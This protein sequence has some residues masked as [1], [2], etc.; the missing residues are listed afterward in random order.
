MPTLL[1][2][3]R[4]L[5]AAA[6]LVGAA[7]EAG[8]SL[9]FL[10]EN[11]ACAPG[12]D[13]VYYGGSDVALAAARRFHLT[14]LEPPLDLVVRLPL[15]F[16]QRAVEYARFD[17]LHRLK[18]PTF[19][20]PA[21]PLNKAFDAGIYADVR[22]IRAPKGIAPATPVLVAEPVEWLAEYRCFVLDR[23]VAATTPYLSFGRPVWRPFGEGGEQAQA[24]PHVLAFCERLFSQS[25]VSFPPALVMDVGL[26]EDR[27][28][29]VVEFNPAWC[30]GLLGVD[31]RRVLAVLRRA[32]HNEEVVSEE[33]RRWVVGR[34]SF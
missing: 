4:S 31:P 12:D 21:D 18:A 30:A 29:A 19:V 10:D 17:E 8:W 22:D 5:P 32:C 23:K 11:P 15:T 14:L 20:K 16:R 2:S 6:A 34:S 7:G 3:T 24:S 33:D 28:W 27:G 13:I 26:I 25:G 1:L 9:A